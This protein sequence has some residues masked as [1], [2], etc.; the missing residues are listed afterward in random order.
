[1]DIL[2]IAIIYLVKGKHDS[3]TGVYVI[4]HSVKSNSWTDIKSRS[5]IFNNFPSMYCCIIHSSVVSGVLYEV[6]VDGNIL[7]PGWTGLPS[8]EI[9]QTLVENLPQ[10][11]LYTDDTLATMDQMFFFIIQGQ[12]THTVKA[13]LQ[14]ALT[15]RWTPFTIAIQGRLRMYITSDSQYVTF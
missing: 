7:T 15:P 14:A 13:D 3:A 5:L 1:M 9:I 6:R 10:V 12:L 4:L 11:T 2:S 8:L